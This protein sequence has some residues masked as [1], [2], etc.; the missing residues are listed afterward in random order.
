MTTTPQSQLEYFQAARVSMPVQRVDHDG[1]LDTTFTETFQGSDS[2]TVVRHPALLC[3]RQEEPEFT[4][5]PVLREFLHIDAIS[6]ESSPIAPAIEKTNISPESVNPLF[7]RPEQLEG[8]QLCRARDLES[9]CN[10]ATMN[11]LLVVALFLPIIVLLSV[12]L[13][14]AAL[15]LK[16]SR[17]K[18]R[19][20]MHGLNDEERRQVI[21]LLS[22]IYW[23]SR[24][25]VIEGAG[26]G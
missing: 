2:E 9:G 22:S 21:D 3:T 14:L 6:P 11:R 23:S 7:V 16:A 1:R 18:V 8:L 17:E 26:A 19:D 10:K 4:V 13:V 24:V 15:T 5:S 25:P 12:L 20:V